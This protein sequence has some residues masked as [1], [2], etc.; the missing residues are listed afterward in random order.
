MNILRVLTQKRRVGNF[1]ED[2]AA[3]FLKKNGYKILCRNYEGGSHEIDIVAEKKGITVFVEVK[4]RNINAKSQ[5]ESRP[6]SSVTPAKQRAI[7]SAAKHYAAFHTPDGQMQFDVIEVYLEQRDGEPHVSEIKH[8]Q[9]TFNY[10]TAYGKR[11][12]A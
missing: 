10:N 7:I 1:G 6:A 2:A 12:K 9:N 4:A 3:K 8:L 11:R 5:K